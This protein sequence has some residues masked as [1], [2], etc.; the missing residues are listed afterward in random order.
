MDQEC[1]H[2]IVAYAVSTDAPPERY[3]RPKAKTLRNT[4]APITDDE[5]NACFDS[6]RQSFSDAI[7]NG[8][9]DRAWKLTSDAAEAALEV[10]NSMGG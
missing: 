7:D 8:D 10:D 6:S 2:S 9:L 3:T 4:G 5:W 1:E